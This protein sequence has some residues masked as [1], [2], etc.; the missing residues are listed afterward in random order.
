MVNAKVYIQLKKGVADPPGL[1]VKEALHSM[2]YGEVVDLH[3]GKVVGLTIQPIAGM[4]VEERIK[5]MCERLLAN[6]VIEDYVI[7]LT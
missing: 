4:D 2:G 7:E 1:T 6:P 3:M 5:E